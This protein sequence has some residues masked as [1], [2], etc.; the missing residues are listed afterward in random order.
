MECLHATA[1]IVDDVG[2]LLRGHSGAGKSDL[3][4]RLIDGGAEL[5][6]DDQVAVQ[7]HS[8]RLIAAAPADLYG[9]IE[10]RGIGLM[11][12]TAA[13]NADIDAIIE[14]VDTASIERLPERAQATINGVTLPLFWLTPFES[15][16]PA[17][18]R[19]IARGL[20]QNI[21]YRPESPDP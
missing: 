14:L 9:I 20:R 11:R 1:V 19:L 8:G 15:S 5:V 21:F 17:K 4:L 18:V 16:A 6:A 13:E 3:A 10:V 7:A 2:L 12:T